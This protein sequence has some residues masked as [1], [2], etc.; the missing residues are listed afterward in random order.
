MKDIKLPSYRET[1]TKTWQSIT[2]MPFHI[3]PC[4]FRLLCSVKKRLKDCEIGESINIITKCDYFM[5]LFDNALI[6]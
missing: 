2:E 1:K 4:R 5:I 6:G 3:K